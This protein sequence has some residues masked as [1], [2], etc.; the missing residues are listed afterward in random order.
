MKTDTVRLLRECNAGVKMGITSIEDVL[1]KVKSEELKGALTQNKEAHQR[2]G[3]RLH[4][5]LNECDESGK[6]PNPMA[7]GM[8]WMKTNLMMQLNDSDQT[9]ADVMTD[10]CN[11]GIKSLNRYL[12]QYQQAEEEARKIAED[13]ISL[14]QNLIEDLRKFL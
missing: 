4:Q 7:R 1:D 3:S 10:G 6:E 9:I 11:M 14:E 13:L 8:S 12:N 5:L 2:L